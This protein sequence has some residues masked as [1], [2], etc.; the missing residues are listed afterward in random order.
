MSIP[1]SSRVIIFPR[2]VAEALFENQALTVRQY[3]KGS[4]VRVRGP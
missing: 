1:P 2:V 3:L 4:V